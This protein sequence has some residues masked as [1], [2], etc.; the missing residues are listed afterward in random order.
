MKG[1]GIS[2]SIKDSLFPFNQFDKILLTQNNHQIDE[3]Y[4]ENID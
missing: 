4:G 3:V 1:I 2:E